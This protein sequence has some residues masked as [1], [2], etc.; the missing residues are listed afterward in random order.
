MKYLRRFNENFNVDKDVHIEIIVGDIIDYLKKNCVDRWEDIFLKSEISNEVND[1]I[2]HYIED[3]SDL[4][5]IKF[6]VCMELNDLDELKEMLP[7]LE[8]KEEYEKCALIKKKL[9]NETFK[10]I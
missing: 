10:G 6:W 4:D 3:L 5:D 8:E 9:D 2:D 1:I 7:K